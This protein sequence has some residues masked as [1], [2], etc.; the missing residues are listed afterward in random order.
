MAFVDTELD[1]KPFQRRGGQRRKEIDVK[2]KFAGR[3]ANIL[4]APGW[5]WAQGHLD[6]VKRNTEEGKCVC[7]CYG[8]IRF[9]YINTD[10]GDII[11]SFL[12]LIWAVEQ[13][14][15]IESSQ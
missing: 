10:L 12:S 1:N 4:C 11:D 14:K 9:N 7:V 5:T 15:F 8:F 3:W 2:S 6:T 13:N